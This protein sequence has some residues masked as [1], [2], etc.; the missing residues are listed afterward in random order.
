M[1]SRW[2]GD[3][4]RAAALMSS[5]LASPTEY[6]L[7]ATDQDGTIMLWSQGAA[8]LYGYAAS[9]VLGNLSWWGMCAA[10]GGAARHDPAPAAAAPAAAASGAT[11]P[12][13]A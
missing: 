6:S 4:W 3:E 10:G 12:G 7:F 2:L 13:T 1:H 9:A 8:R 11:S 5:I